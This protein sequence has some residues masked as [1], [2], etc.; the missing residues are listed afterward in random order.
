MRLTLRTRQCERAGCEVRDRVARHVE[1]S[2]VGS[3]VVVKDDSCR[4]ATGAG[5]QSCP[6]R[7]DSCPLLPRRSVLRP[8]IPGEGAPDYP[9]PL[10]DQRL[11]ASSSLASPLTHADS[12]HPATLWGRS[13]GMFPRSSASLSARA[14]P[15]QPAPA[16]NP[17]LTRRARCSRPIWD[18]SVRRGRDRAERPRRGRARRHVTAVTRRSASRARPGQSRPDRCGR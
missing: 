13:A 14:R 5:R 17:L 11:A 8:P 18:T 12:W 3:S 16:G 1:M 2:E 15:T 6:S 7:P 4:N 10:Y 9:W